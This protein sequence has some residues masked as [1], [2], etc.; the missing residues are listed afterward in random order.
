MKKLQNL[1]IFLKIALIIT[2]FLISFFTI[3][4][5]QIDFIGYVS[6][7]AALF[8]VNEAFG[9]SLFIKILL[10][11]FLGLIISLF[12]ILPAEQ[13]THIRPVGSVIF[14]NCLRM[15]LVPLV[16]ASILT[17]I[18]SLGDIKKLNLIG[19]RTIV[20]YMIT[21][22]IAITIGLTLANIFQPGSDLGQDNN[23]KAMFEQSQKA[24]AESSVSSANQNRQTAF[25][26]LLAIFPRN[27][28]ETVSD[29]S[30]NML[31]LI[32]FAVICGIALLQIK[33]E[34][35][36]P[37]VKFFTG[38]TEMT[39]KLIVMVM[40]LAPYGVFALIASQIASTQNT[41]LILALVP[42]SL[43]VIGALALHMFLL[44]GLSLKYLSKF[45]VRFFFKNVKEVMIT[46]FS[47]SSSGATMPL[48]LETVERDLKVKNE[49]GGFVIPLG[50]TINMD[51][52]ALFQGVSAIFLANI[53]GVDLGLYEQLVVVLLVVMAS[54]GTAA[55]PG[56][57]IVMLTLVLVEVG[58]PPEGILFILP[59]NNL[60]DMFRTVVNVVGDMTC[61]VYINT[62]YEKG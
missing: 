23:I 7:F 2:F 60:L 40:R 17:G 26:G 29:G 59:V 49:V 54:I 62:I 51:G 21:T 35:S 18:T 8:V 31:Q 12:E 20:Y 6:L 38:I 33:D 42:F 3:G 43:I 16:F 48:T 28:M 55:V 22:A 1:N 30:P 61:S 45:D 41:D 47:T 24:S 9:F 39:I 58:I 10:A 11:L 52:T 44:N 53:Y 4:Q 13:I 5:P 56:V 46:A 50:A 25:E 27:I 57:G 14:M 19:S 32:F 36:D 37:V 34:Y 15:A